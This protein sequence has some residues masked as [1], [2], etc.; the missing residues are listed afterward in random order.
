[1]G[2]P[3]EQVEP[4]FNNVESLLLYNLQLLKA[5]EGG[6]EGDNAASAAEGAA[7]RVARAFTD[8]LP[9]FRMYS[10]YSVG[11]RTSL[12]QLARLV[13]EFPSL[14]RFLDQCAK[15][16]GLLSAE[17]ALQNLL[18]AP[19]QRIC[20]YPLFFRDL[21]K[22]VP[23]SDPGRAALEDAAAQVNA[24]SQE[25]NDKVRVAEERQQMVEFYKRLGETAPEGL[26][27]PQRRLV[28]E[29]VVHMQRERSRS[30][31][32]YVLVLFNDIIV[33]A[34]P[35]RKGHYDWTQLRGP[36]RD[37]RG[38]LLRLHTKSVWALKDVTVRHVEGSETPRGFP[39]TLMKAGTAAGLDGYVGTTVERFHVWV[40]LA[41]ERTR[42]VTAITECR[43]KVIETRNN[44]QMRGASDE[45]EIVPADGLTLTIDI[46]IKHKT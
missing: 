28:L 38:E 35:D 1:M 19:V 23:R 5:L 17:R 7:A 26:V 6:E 12:E 41:P 34:R 14:N 13:Q 27:Q 36:Q 37:G 11:Y 42:L 16:A 3:L 22:R 44:L 46:D 21:L 4:V 45:P 18:I 25:V 8:V 33:L 43:V 24:I 20:K 2:V 9:F 29:T 32:K 30:V 10:V 39:F 31:K 40:K 15:N